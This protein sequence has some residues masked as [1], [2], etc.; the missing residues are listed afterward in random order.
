M[1]TI[2]HPESR[3]GVKSNQTT[4]LTPCPALTVPTT[5]LTKLFSDVENVYGVWPHDSWLGSFSMIT[6]TVTTPERTGSPLSLAAR[7]TCKA[8]RDKNVDENHHCW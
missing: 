6:V 4:S 8:E 7:M 1:D 5:V 3:E 2:Q